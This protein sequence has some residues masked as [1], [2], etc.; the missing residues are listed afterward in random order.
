MF[1][2]TITFIYRNPRNNCKMTSSSIN[3]IVSTL[4]VISFFSIFYDNVDS[5]SIEQNSSSHMNINASDVYTKE[6]FVVPSNVTNYVILIPN[7]AHESPEEK[8]KLIS[9]HNSYFLPKNLVITE[10]TTI[11]FIIADAPWDTPHPH[12]I[13]IKN[14]EKETVYT[15]PKLEYGDFSKTILLD[16]GKYSISDEIY[17][18]MKG[19]I[20][21]LKKD[22][23]NETQNPQPNDKKSI[24]MGGFYS[25]TFTVSDA[26]DNSGVVHPGNSLKYY[27]TKFNE[28]GLT[29]E[30]TFNFSY[31]E[32]SYCEGKYWPDNKT[33]DHTLI[34]FSTEKPYDILIKD[35]Q[36]LIKDN[37]Y[38]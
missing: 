33:G 19:T 32:C 14:D 27:I 30:D 12:T 13:L 16:A 37:V 29:I 26:T 34:L 9:D 35:L 18:F 24:V 22:F 6:L 7:E 20:T 25:P 38:I 10:G 3:F 21:V 23:S 28:N 8:H 11:S 5:F 4:I 15:S 2:G 1:I 31:A 36:K 17:N